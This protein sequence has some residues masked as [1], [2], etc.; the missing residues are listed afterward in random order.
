MDSWVSK[1]SD[2]WKEE[3]GK[4]GKEKEDRVKRRRR[5]VY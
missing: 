3:N 4:K 1:G 2:G 5:E